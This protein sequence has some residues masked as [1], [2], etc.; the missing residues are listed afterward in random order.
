MRETKHPSSLS[1][2]LL[3][4][5]GLGKAAGEHLLELSLDACLVDEY[6]LAHSHMVHHARASPSSS[7]RCRSSGCGGERCRQVHCGSSI[8]CCGIQQRSG[9]R[10]IHWL[11]G[12][13]CSGLRPH[14]GSLRRAPSELPFLLIGTTK[15]V[16]CRTPPHHR[17]L[18]S[19]IDQ[20]PTS[21]HNE[22][23]AH[24]VWG[25]ELPC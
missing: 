13:Q 24:K 22:G 18:G 25:R 16:W 11:H 7:M 12:N 9:K 8:R 10:C 14:H 19:Q 20:L 21:F 4:Q 15:P 1:G 2:R 5:D 17:S 6:L 3:R 23:T